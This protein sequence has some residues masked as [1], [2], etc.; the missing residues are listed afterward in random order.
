MS[1][2]VTQALV[3]YSEKQ[4]RR[5]PLKMSCEKCIKDFQS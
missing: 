3:H 2:N 5:F 1:K 4:L